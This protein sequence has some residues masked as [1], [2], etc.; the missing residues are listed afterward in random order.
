MREACTIC[1]ADLPVG[2][3]DYL[4][5]GCRGRRI[6]D[7]RDTRPKIGPMQYPVLFTHLKGEA[8]RM[9]NA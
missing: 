7:H 9:F 5:E 3:E 4:C 2:R 1:D 8:L 6:V